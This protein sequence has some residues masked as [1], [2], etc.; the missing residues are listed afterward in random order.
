MLCWVFAQC[1]KKIRTEQ[2][3]YLLKIELD[4]IKNTEVILNRILS[5]DMEISNINIETTEDEKVVL[6][7]E[8]GLSQKITSKGIMNTVSGMGTL[9]DFSI[10]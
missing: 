9:K 10:I 7:L 3:N 4:S 1:R 6:S 2:T 8:L 5:E